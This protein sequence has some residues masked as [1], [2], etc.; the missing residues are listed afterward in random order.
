MEQLLSKTAEHDAIEIRDELTGYSLL[1]IAL[2]YYITGLD[3]TALPACQHF[4]PFSGSNR[5]LIDQYCLLTARNSKCSLKIIMLGRMYLQLLTIWWLMTSDM[6]VIAGNHLYLG[7][8]GNLSALGL[9]KMCLQDT[10]HDCHIT[11][12][13]NFLSSRLAT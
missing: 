4:S 8:A 13:H 12:D 2:H 1:V 6:P 7:G 5:W 9:W 11:D 3:I 10:V